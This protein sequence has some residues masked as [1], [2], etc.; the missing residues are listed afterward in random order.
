M[1]STGNLIDWNA[2]KEYQST[3]KRERVKTIVCVVSVGAQCCIE[4][5]SYAE[6]I[7]WCDEGLK[8]HP[9]DKKLLE[10]RASA[11]KHRVE[12]LLN[13]CFCCSCCCGRLVVPINCNTLF[14]CT[15]ESCRERF[16]EGQT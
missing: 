1:F 7:Q 9:A 13:I 15:Q 6:T 10:L 3:Q 16:Q 2:T 4:L 5:R 14:F 11:D 12:I 8:A